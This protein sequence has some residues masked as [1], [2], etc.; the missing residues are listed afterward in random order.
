MGKVMKGLFHGTWGKV[1]KGK[2]LIKRE[3][4]SDGSSD[5]IGA[6]FL[7]DESGKINMAHYGKFLG[8]HLPI[9]EIKNS[10]D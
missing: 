6:D 3:I 10:L 9:T 1:K 8:D 2:R 5:R 7:I 4:K